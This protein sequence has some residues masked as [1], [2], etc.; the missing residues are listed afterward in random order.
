MAAGKGRTTRTG[1][2]LCFHQV[3]FHLYNT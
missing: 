1:V 2:M 3:V